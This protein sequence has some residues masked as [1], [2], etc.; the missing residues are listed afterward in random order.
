M[1]WTATDMLASAARPIVYGSQGAIEPAT[2][3]WHVVE[4]SGSAQVAG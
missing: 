3:E 1:S 4:R 2:M